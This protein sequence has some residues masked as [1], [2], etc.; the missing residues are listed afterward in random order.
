MPTFDSYRDQSIEILHSSKTYLLA[1][2]RLL[3]ASLF[4]W[5]GVLQLRNPSATAQYF[6]SVHVPVSGVAVWVS[7][8]SVD[9]D[10]HTPVALGTL[11]INF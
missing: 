8:A 5:D 2:A 11:P 1:F 7:R 4:V 6:E 3:M 10:G 9:V